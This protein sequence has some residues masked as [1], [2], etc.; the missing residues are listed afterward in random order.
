MTLDNK[1]AEYRHYSDVDTAFVGK[2]IKVVDMPKGEEDVIGCTSIRDYIHINY[3]HPIMDDLTD[4]QKVVFRCGVNA[5]ELLHKLLSNF[6]ALNKHIKSFPESEQ[7]IFLQIQNVMEDPAIEFFGNQEIGGDLIE[8]LRFTIAHVCRKAKPIHSYPSGFSQFITACIHFGDMGALK[9]VFT[10]DLAKSIFKEAA[11]I[12]DACIEEPDAEKRLMYA[13]DVFELSRPLWQAT[14]NMNELLRQLSQVMKNNGKN[15]KAEHGEAIIK[16][17]RCSSS[18]S[19]KLNQVSA[20]RK[21]L[22]A[23]IEKANNAENTDDYDDDD[24]DEL[25]DNYSSGNFSDEFEE[26]DDDENS[27]NGSPNSFDDE[28]DEEKDGSNGT[29]NEDSLSEEDKENDKDGKSCSESDDADQDEDDSE[30]GDGNN[31]D[32]SS[33]ENDSAPKKGNSG[34]DEEDDEDF[35]D[36]NDWG[37]NPQDDNSDNNSSSENNKKSGSDQENGNQQ[38]K[39]GSMPDIDMTS[40]VETNSVYEV[41]ISKEEYEIPESV[42][43]SMLNKI[44]EERTV[45]EKSIDEIIND[46]TP[47]LE[48]VLASPLW[49][50]KIKCNNKIIT[51][52]WN[53][54]SSEQIYSVFRNKLGGL[55]KILFGQLNRIFIQD[56]EE[57]MYRASGKVDMKRLASG[58]VTAKLFYKKKD[59]SNKHNMIIFILFDRSGSMSG[60]KIEAVKELLVLLSEVFGKLK[61]PIYIMGYSEES[62]GQVEHR[63]Y[64]RWNNTAK[65]RLKLME[66]STGGCN[67]DG[68][69]IRYATEILKQK[70][71][72]HKLLIALSDGAPA[73]SHYKRDTSN[74]VNDTRNAVKE[75]KKIASVLGV[76]IGDSHLDAIKFIYE[77]DFLHINDVGE[78]TTSLAKAIKKIVSKWE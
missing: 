47:A 51:L 55:I 60:T 64:I 66:I 20:R 4:E 22:L 75:A 19:K 52:P 62:G 7:P 1:Q 71:A 33:D 65:E 17:T 15:C 73:S 74:A 35:A 53:L 43:T 27:R 49:Q 63:H 54:I 13:K 72:D 69:S 23:Q 5:H 56:I 42:I 18:S 58:Q 11:P 61:I 40:D 21:N 67:F 25:D 78:M 2:S 45:M 16:P 14:A 6:I 26:E 34:D 59:P 3:S 76:A 10:D 8:S 37:D 39:N 68:Y 38:E 32:G 12:I 28:T 57:I 46:N 50:G 36:M 31:Q 77:R 30:N 70:E 29:Q 24:M 9:G 44:S 41:E 48:P